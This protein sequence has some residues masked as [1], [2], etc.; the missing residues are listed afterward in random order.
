MEKSTFLLSDIT[1]ADPLLF[2]ILF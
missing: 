1:T 2:Y